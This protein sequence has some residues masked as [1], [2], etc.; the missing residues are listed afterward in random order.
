MYNTES[1]MGAAI[2]ESIA[3]GVVKREDLF[4]TTKISSNFME[5]Q[6]A[7]DISLQKLRLDYVDLYVSAISLNPVSLSLLG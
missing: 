4:I 3:E 6:T 1:E 2:Q 7:I 5:V